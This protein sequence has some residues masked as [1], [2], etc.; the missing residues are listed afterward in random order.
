MS[1]L[2]SVLFWLWVCLCLPVFSLWFWAGS[3]V[4]FAPDKPPAPALPR[5]AEEAIEG[6][7]TVEG[8]DQNGKY[9]GIAAI[10]RRGN[11]YQIAWLIGKS[12]AVVGTG[13]RTGNVL[14]VGFGDGRVSVI[15]RYQI[16]MADGKP[17]LVGK[18]H[19]LAEAEGS[20][21]M[22]F[23]KEFPKKDDK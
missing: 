22:L 5:P 12:S 16:E 10:A 2:P 3:L 19:S 1:R 4:A 15:C 9:G 17:K 6:Y 8:E 21:T 11:V 23:L 14:T 18:W 7:Y 13:M 20:E